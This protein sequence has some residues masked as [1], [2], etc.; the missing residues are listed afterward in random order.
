MYCNFFS[1]LHLTKRKQIKIFEL[2]CTI[3]IVVKLVESDGSYEIWNILR[4][5]QKLIMILAI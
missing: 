2:I 4:I 5:L 1:P 3:N